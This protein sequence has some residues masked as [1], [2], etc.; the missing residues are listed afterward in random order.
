MAEVAA[1]PCGHGR[2]RLD[3]GTGRGVYGPPGGEHHGADT[4]EHPAEGLVLLGD[5]LVL[6]GLEPG[7]PRGLIGFVAEGVGPVGG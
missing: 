6:L 1:G 5:P 4:D 2:R 3:G 7:V